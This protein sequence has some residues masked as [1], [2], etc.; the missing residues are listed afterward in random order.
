MS[1]SEQHTITAIIHAS[2]ITGKQL[3]DAAASVK[4]LAMRFDATGRQ[5]CS[6]RGLARISR[7]AWMLGARDKWST[8]GMSFEDLCS[9][10][11]THILK[12]ILPK[13]EPRYVF[14]PNVTGDGWRPDLGVQ[15]PIKT[16]MDRFTTWMTMVAAGGGV[17]YL[18]WRC[19]TDVINHLT[20]RANWNTIGAT[21]VRAWM[22]CM[23]RD[24]KEL[25]RA[26]AKDVDRA[27]EQAT[28]I[29]R[30]WCKKAYAAPRGCMYRQSLTL[31][32]GIV[33]QG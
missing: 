16:Q 17:R 6:P 33:Q 11:D 25:T 27:N 14:L 29:Q 5:T 19:L 23:E 18:E 31:V 13:C 32:E 20:D 1:D 30:A 28:A 2:C 15:S 26:C 3:M 24:R 7:F 4:D 22:Q 8:D 12:H 21:T 10:L 9:T